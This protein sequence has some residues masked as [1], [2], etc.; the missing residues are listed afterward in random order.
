MALKI[1]FTGD[2]SNFIA[3]ANE[4]RKA[5]RALQT[6]V[7]ESLDESKGKMRES[8]EELEKSRQKLEELQKKANTNWT[9]PALL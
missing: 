7:S 5:V 8:T 1:A 6:Q 2:N 9:R 3:K 4:A